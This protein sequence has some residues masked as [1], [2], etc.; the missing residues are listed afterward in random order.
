M[1]RFGYLKKSVLLFIMISITDIN[2]EVVGIAE[3]YSPYQYFDKYTKKA[4]GLDY[5]LVKAILDNINI[6]TIFYQ[7]NWN[8][9][10]AQFK[11]GNKIDIVTGMEITNLRKTFAMFSNVIY[12][13]HS[14]IFVLDESEI[15][16][17]QDLRGRKVTGDRDSYSEELLSKEGLKNNIRLLQ[18]SSKEEAFLLLKNGTTAAAIM[19]E[20]VGIYLAGLYNIRVRLIHRN[21]VGSPVG[22]A[23]KNG[24]DELLNKI[25]ISI[26]ELQDRGEIDKI[27]QK[28]IS[29]EF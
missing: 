12:Y 17:L 15:N 7:D 10:V 19:P 6:A 24:N 26:K 1:F 29:A 16:F 14:G 9:V 25:N 23:L 22:I 5:D 21:S 2:S 18:T 11:F 13:R 28:W 3:G 27:M 4:S 8:N 20:I